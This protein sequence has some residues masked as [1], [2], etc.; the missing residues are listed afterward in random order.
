M[1][2]KLKK[3][4]QQQERIKLEISKEKKKGLNQQRK[5]DTRRKILIGAIVL[6]EMKKDSSLKTKFDNLLE[7]KLT[8][9]NDRI[10]FELEPL[11]K[12]EKSTTN[13]A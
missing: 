13:N 6:E 4:E 8:R 5:R 9:D 3:L 1:T 2:T 7:S 12:K 11:L 10:L